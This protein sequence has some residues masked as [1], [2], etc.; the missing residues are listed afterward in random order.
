M[1]V[2]LLLLLLLMTGAEV[3]VVVVL[4]PFPIFCRDC[5]C[6]FEYLLSYY[7]LYHQAEMQTIHYL[8]YVYPCAFFV[9]VGDVV[10][11]RQAKSWTMT[12]TDDDDD[13]LAMIMMMKK[14]YR[15][16]N[17]TYCFSPSFWRC[18][19]HSH[20]LQDDVDVDVVVVID[21]AAE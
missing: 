4:P 15:Y 20:H 19:C 16:S 5:S 21:A 17:P 3:H 8:Q 1:S 7:Y 11:G 13:L 6:S 18:C 10:V 9:V 12:T 14:L 2:L